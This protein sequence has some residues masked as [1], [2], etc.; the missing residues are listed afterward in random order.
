MR[1]LSA[2][3]FLASLFAFPPAAVAQGAP[4]C[5]VAADP[6]FG[7]SVQKAIPIGG[8]PAL[9]GARQ[10]R[11]MGVLRGPGGEV[12]NAGVTRT[13]APNPETKAII[14]I[15]QVTYPG[16]ET[17]IGLYFNAYAFATPQVPQGFS[18]SEPLAAALGPP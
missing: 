17:P 1:V 5:A 7:L 15:Y 16:R 10:R 12:V 13:T 2:I 9:A 3:V 11:Y 4:L 8:G 18:C 6:E 14:D